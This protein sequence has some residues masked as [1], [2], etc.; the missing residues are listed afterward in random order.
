VTGGGVPPR[1]PISGPRGFT[2]ARLPASATDPATA[3]A[4]H[5]VGS[6]ARSARSIPAT[7]SSGASRPRF[8]RRNPPSSPWPNVLRM[9]AGFTEVCTHVT[10]P[11]KD[12]GGSK[13]SRTPVILD[14]C[15]VPV[16]RNLLPPAAAPCQPLRRAGIFDRNARARPPATAP[17]GFSVKGRD[18]NRP[19]HPGS[20][21]EQ[22]QAPASSR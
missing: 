20:T 6:A 10:C 2:R 18:A 5:L 8:P 15:T 22:V 1:R 19:R 11:A 21:P 4:A 7:S 14:S 3:L 13:P 16:V 9:G 12:R 17:S